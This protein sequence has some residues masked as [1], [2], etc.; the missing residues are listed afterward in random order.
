MRFST[1]I[2]YKLHRI[3]L[4]ICNCSVLGNMIT[5]N[6]VPINGLTGRY[7]FVVY[8]YLFNYIMSIFRYLIYMCSLIP[9]QRHFSCEVICLSIS[10]EGYVFKIDI[11]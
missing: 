6:G 3:A 5:V 2:V 10:R 11:S 4:P 1:A 9:F 7:F 8:F